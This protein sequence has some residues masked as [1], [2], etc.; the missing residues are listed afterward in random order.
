MLQIKYHLYPVNQSIG[1]I[2]VKVKTVFLLFRLIT[3]KNILHKSTK[4]SMLYFESKYF[5]K[6]IYSLLP[7]ESK[8]I[9]TFE[10]E[11]LVVIMQMV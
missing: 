9:Y 10:T 7:S 1:T 11:H 8:I 5:I 2:L 4:L 3:V 6:S